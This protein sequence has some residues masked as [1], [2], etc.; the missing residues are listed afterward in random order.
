MGRREMFE[1]ILCRDPVEFAS[2]EQRGTFSRAF[3]SL[4]PEMMW[5]CGSSFNRIHSF[6]ILHQRLLGFLPAPLTLF[7]LLFLL[8]LRLCSC[9]S[10]RFTPMRES[11]VKSFHLLFLLY[12]RSGVTRIPLRSEAEDSRSQFFGNKLKTNR[13]K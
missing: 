4:V 2:E 8:Y 5:R 10:A 9:V 12:S 6:H 13:E 1:L 3:I 7:I 11:R